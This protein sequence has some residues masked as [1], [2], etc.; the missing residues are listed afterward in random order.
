MANSAPQHISL[1]SRDQFDA[2]EEGHSSASDS[3]YQHALEVVFDAQNAHRRKSSLVTAD[4]PAATFQRRKNTECY[5]HA[6]LESQRKSGR[7]SNSGLEGIAE[8]L[9]S[10][11][12]ASGKDE[13]DDKE[14]AVVDKKMHNHNE[15]EDCGQFDETSWRDT[16]KAKDATQPVEDDASGKVQLQPDGMDA[17]ATHSR[18]LTKKQLSDM[19]WGV[20][21]L[22]KRLGSI[23]LK[24][25]VRTVFILTKVHDESLIANTREVTRWLLSPERQVRYTVFVEENLR[26][27]KK[28]DAKGL[29]DELEEAEEGKINGD[30]HKR[31][32]YWSSNMCRTRPHTF[33]FIITLGG[34]GTVLYASWLFQRIVPPVLSFALG[35]LGFLTK[36]DFGD[37]EKQLTTAFRDGVT[38]SLRLRF[39]GTVM[40][41]QTRKPKAVTDGENGDED[42][43][44]ERDLV[45]ELVGEEMGDERTHRPDGTYE[46]L[47]DIVVDRGPNPTMSSIEIFGD[48][49]HFT[50][51][52]AD[53]VCVATPTGSTAYNLAAG[54]SL[55]HPENPVILVS[56]IC[57]HTLSFRPI[58]LP[59]TIVLRLGVPYDARTSSWASFD[60]RERVELN[61]GDYVTISASR[62]PFANVMPQG[63][64]SEDWVNSI[65]GK[66]GWNTRQRQKGYKEWST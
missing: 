45:E 3:E 43:I 48:D 31:L 39:E 5:V 37:F 22:S 25:K 59:D 32:R 46:I 36:F 2:H 40:R 58:I 23:R 64:R 12:I 17:G 6:L 53:G 20:R 27:S 54:G 62:Y 57:A 13:T 55:C 61:P 44:P 65:S 47:N 50:S 33:D 4:T 8:T 19:A 41:S 7:A 60:G 49:E 11:R 34:D 15:E 56:A 9:A 51:V 52:Q 35:S 18:L 1:P 21:E 14:D 42:T 24:L 26:D 29:L 38:I 16:F 30:K 28:F 10:R 66:L 63:R